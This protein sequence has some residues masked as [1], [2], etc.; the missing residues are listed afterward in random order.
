M[1]G[2]RIVVL[3]SVQAAIALL[4]KRGSIYS[5]RPIMTMVGELMAWG[6]TLVFSPYGSRF[7]DIRKFLHRYIGSRGQLEKIAP[8]HDLLEAETRR[9]LARLHRDPEHFVDHLRK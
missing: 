1:L 2:Q 7:R 5:D 9:F 6:E 4:E 3:N 8:F